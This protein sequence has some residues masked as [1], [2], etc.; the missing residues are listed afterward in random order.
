MYNPIHPSSC[1]QPSST[2]SGRNQPKFSCHVDS[3]WSCNLPLEQ[4]YKLEQYVWIP[5]RR[6]CNLLLV[7]DQSKSASHACD[8]FYHLFLI[9]F[10]TNPSN[11]ITLAIAF[12]RRR[13]NVK[14][15][16]R[17][18]CVLAK[19][20]RCPLSLR[21]VYWIKFEL[22]ANLWPIWQYSELCSPYWSCPCPLSLLQ[23]QM[24]ILC[25]FLWTRS[26]GAN[27]IF[28]KIGA[29][30]QDSMHWCPA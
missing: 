11:V 19:S 10:A 5:F 3:F 30:F 7:E 9:Y 6:V 17:E 23:L 29:N 8:N 16:A 15:M 4:K 22:K 27:C 25:R 1:I 28:S 21:S 26:T 14:L 20:A 24:K 12:I 2:T 13:R 18:G